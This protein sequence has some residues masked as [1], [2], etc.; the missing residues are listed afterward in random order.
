MN[1]RLN[2]E[3]HKPH[4]MKIVARWNYLTAD[5]RQHTI[6]PEQDGSIPGPYFK[7]LIV[8]FTFDCTGAG[9]GA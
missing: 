7:A 8:A 4:E 3:R 6:R 5:P 9:K 2:H 1:L